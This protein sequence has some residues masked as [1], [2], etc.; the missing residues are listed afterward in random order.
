MSSSVPRAILQACGAHGRKASLSAARQSRRWPSNVKFDPRG[1]SSVV[2]AA[3]CFRQSRPY[4]SESRQ[5][6]AQ[7]KTDIA[8]DMSQQSAATR[9]GLP[10]EVV[11][12][13]AITVGADSMMSPTAGSPPHSL[14]ERSPSCSR[15]NTRLRYP[16][17][18]NSH[19]SRSTANISRYAGYYAPRSACT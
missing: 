7:V 5:N 4:V 17:A 15:T 12:G 14:T 19:G 10:A 11:S 9:S 2:P 13:A 6:N 3:V 18:S 1:R 8:V 16:Q